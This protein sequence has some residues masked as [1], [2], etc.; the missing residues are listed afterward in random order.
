MVKTV[1]QRLV[2]DTA[3]YQPVP[4]MSYQQAIKILLDTPLP[5]R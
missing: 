2:F 4:A 5:T 3:D 1:H